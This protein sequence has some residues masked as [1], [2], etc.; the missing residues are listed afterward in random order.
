MPTQTMN[1]PICGAKHFAAP[2][3]GKAAPREGPSCP[4]QGGQY[5]GLRSGHDQLY[6]GRWRRM[7]ATPFDIRQAFHQLERLLGRITDALESESLP[8]ARRDLEKA[9]DALQT[10]DPDEGKP[11]DI[12]H[13]DHALS[14]AHRVIGDLLHEKGLPPHSPADFAEWYD[15]AEVPFRE[16]W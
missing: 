7:D 5:V 2:G 14:Y 6:F 10:A 8:A 4:Y 12:L 15:A 16:D 3:G 1:C 13:M 11:A 9:L